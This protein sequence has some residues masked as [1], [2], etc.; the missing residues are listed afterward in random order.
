MP[1]VWKEFITP[2]GWPV[3]KETEEP[4]ASVPILLGLG[5]TP[6][7][8]PITALAVT[9]TTGAVLFV[10]DVLLA[11]SIGVLTWRRVCAV[12]SLQ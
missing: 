9:G 4:V 3:I 2:L 11:F 5:T 8:V 12:D 1:G 6:L 10:N 7:N